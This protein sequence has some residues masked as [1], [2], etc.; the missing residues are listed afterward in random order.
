MNVAGKPVCTGARVARS[1]SSVDGGGPRCHSIAAS[2]GGSAPV[3]TTCPPSVTSG[4]PRY[5]ESACGSQE[6]RA[7]SRIAACFTTAP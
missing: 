6:A 7:S 2:S 3:E 1:T 5:D 4:S